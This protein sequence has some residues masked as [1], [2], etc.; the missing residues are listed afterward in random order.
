MDI[1]SATLGCCSPRSRT[2]KEKIKPTYNDPHHHYK[3]LSHTPMN[4]PNE[5]SLP[6]PHL[7][8]EDATSAILS[9]LLNAEKPGPT[10]ELTIQDLAA[11]AGGW[12]EWLAVSVLNAL[13]K[14]LKEG[15]NLLRGAMKEAYEKARIAAENIKDFAHDHPLYTAAICVVIALGVLVILSPVVIHALGFT[16]AGVEAGMLDFYFFFPPFCFPNSCFFF[17]V[18]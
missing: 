9:A 3:P 15:T 10:L 7:S 13:Q 17:F 12:S 4:Y 11:Q 8:T 2:N 14:V 18:F 16:A 5:K 6:P 1:L